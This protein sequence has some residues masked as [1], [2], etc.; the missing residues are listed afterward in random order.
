MAP[1]Y[2]FKLSGTHFRRQV[3]IR[4]FIVDFACH[5]ARLVVEL[6]GGQHGL[7]TAADAERT[8][9]IEADG[10]RVLRFWNND[11]LGNIDGVLEEIQRALTTTPTPIP[12]PQGGFAQ[13]PH[14]A[15]KRSRLHKNLVQQRVVTKLD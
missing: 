8:R 7:R 10:Y 11:V 5:S 14:A 9:V 4:S 3:R 15:Q 6:D 2:R 13:I 1:A 12:S